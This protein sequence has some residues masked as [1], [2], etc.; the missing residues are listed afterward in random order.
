[1]YGC[2]VADS[3]QTDFNMRNVQSCS[4]IS[5]PGFFFDYALDGQLKYYYRFYHSSIFSINFSIGIIF[6]PN[7][8]LAVVSPKIETEKVRVGTPGQTTFTGDAF[9]K[10]Y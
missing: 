2:G 7:R 6:G 10:S 3:F 5:R 1:M 4:P 8:C 9:R